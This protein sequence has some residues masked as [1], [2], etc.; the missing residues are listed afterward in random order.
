MESFIYTNN[1]VLPP[2]LCDA[3]IRAFENSNLISKGVTC[4]K[5]GIVLDESVKISTCI[6]ITPQ[7]ENDSSWKPLLQELYRILDDEKK[8]YTHK[9]IGC[10]Y[11]GKLGRA[12]H[13]CEIVKYNPNEGFF[14]YHCERGSPRNKTRVLAWMIYL[15]DIQDK[16]GTEFYYQ[17]HI[18][19]AERGKIVIWP[20]DWMHIHRG[21]VSP[22][23]QKF[24]LTGWFVF[25][26]TDKDS[27]KLPM[28]P[29]ED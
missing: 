16:G 29:L 13:G 20:S 8:K 10:Q 3:F 2:D 27:M 7:L 21:E 1:N 26:E 18:E 25:D 19:K 12:Y 4:G 22:S 6:G 17:D 14:T 5:D 15:N 24:I 9:Y 23:E 11:I 28:K